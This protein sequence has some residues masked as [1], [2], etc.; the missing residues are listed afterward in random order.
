MRT[1][2]FEVAKGWEDK[3]ITLPVRSTKNSA[4]YD[5]A[6][7]EDVVVPVF[8]KGCKPTLVHTGLKAYCQPDEWYMLANRSSGPGKRK[9]VLANGI[10]IIDADFYNNPDNEGHMWFALQNHG[11]KTFKVEAGQGFGQGIFMKYY[12]VDEEEVNTERTGWSGKP[13]ERG[14]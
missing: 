7:A 9:L 6:A 5:V 13:D 12:T 4:G 8:E 10:G 1:R 2:G 14:K 11:D 3:D